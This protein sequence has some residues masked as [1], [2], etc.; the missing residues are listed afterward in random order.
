[1]DFSECHS[2]EVISFFWRSVYIR[3]VMCLAVEASGYSVVGMLCISMT[4]L[5]EFALIAVF[6]LFFILLFSS[7]TLTSFDPFLPIL[8][9]VPNLFHWGCYFYFC[10]TFNSIFYL[11][12]LKMYSLISVLPLSFLV[13]PPLP[14]SSPPSPPPPPHPNPCSL[15]VVALLT[16]L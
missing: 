9:A 4:Q 10:H 6:L 2:E 15:P 14:P 16:C 13:L 5:S 12:L 8:N 7:P 1:M 11:F 3:H